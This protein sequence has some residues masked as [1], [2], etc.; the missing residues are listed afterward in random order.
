MTTATAT[1]TNWSG[2]CQGGPWAGRRMV[3]D[4]QRVYVPILAPIRVRIGVDEP[5]S[6]MQGYYEFEH[7][8]WC[9]HTP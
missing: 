1:G 7:G 5:S 2:W 8:A 6:V 9:W 4:E 3:H